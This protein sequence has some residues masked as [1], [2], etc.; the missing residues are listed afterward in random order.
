MPEQSIEEA[1]ALS[2]EHVK[3]ALAFVPYDDAEDRRC[4]VENAA[5]TIR[6]AQMA[7]LDEMERANQNFKSPGIRA[8]I[9]ALGGD[10]DA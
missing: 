4:A 9:A 6:N 5:L 3:T 1:F 8:R 7:V 10:G 2:M